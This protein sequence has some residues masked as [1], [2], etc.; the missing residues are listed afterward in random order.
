MAKS[1]R[2]KARVAFQEV[3]EESRLR[4]GAYYVAPKNFQDFYYSEPDYVRNWLRSRKANCPIGLL[5]DFEQDILLHLM[6]CPPSAKRAGA[7]D[8]IGT[9]RAEKMGGYGTRHA[10][11]AYVGYMVCNRYIQLI[12]KNKTQRI[13]GDQTVSLG[14]HGEDYLYN[15]VNPDPCAEIHEIGPTIIKKLSTGEDSIWLGVDI[16]RLSEEV[17]LRLGEDH[18]ALLRG[19]LQ[20]ESLEEAGRRLSIPGAH[21]A[22]MF[23][24]IRKVADDYDKFGRWDVMAKVRDNVR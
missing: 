3:N 5:E 8:R 9:Y 15:S 10:F 20:L 2:Y 22:T 6:S 24:R 13:S 12:A 18:Y 11:L 7:E 1:H 17:R 4:G 23:R 16:D 19:Y 14:I 21:S